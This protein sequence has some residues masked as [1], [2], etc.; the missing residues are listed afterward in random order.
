LNPLLLIV[1]DHAD[2]LELH[3][4]ELGRFG[5]EIIT[6]NSGPAAI[7]RAIEFCPAVILM[8]ISMPGMDG[9]QA[10]V[11]IR[12]AIGD[13]PIAALTSTPSQ[14]SKEERLLFVAVFSKP[15]P[16]A[17]VAATLRRAIEKSA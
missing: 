9:C 2:S 6:A 12:Q 8:D 14:L 1:D 10:A 7:A 16:A 5:F 11:H 13:V 3:A 15:C 17:A 4:L